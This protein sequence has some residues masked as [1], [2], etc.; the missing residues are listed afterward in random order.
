MGRL[1]T[2]QEE[3]GMGGGVGRRKR[4]R[5]LESHMKMRGFLK[6]GWNGNLF[7]GP[8]RLNARVYNVQRSNRHPYCIRERFRACL[9]ILGMHVGRYSLKWSS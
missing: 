5:S 1:L 4:G 8:G 6:A 7:L 3:F 2:G 9:W